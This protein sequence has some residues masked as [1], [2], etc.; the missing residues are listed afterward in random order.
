[1]PCLGHRHGGV[2]RAGEQPVLLDP[3]LEAS[4]AAP[5]AVPPPASPSAQCK[6]LRPDRLAPLTANLPSQEKVFGLSAMSASSKLMMKMATTR[7]STW[8][9]K[10]PFSNAPSR[11]PARLQT[12]LH[13]EPRSCAAARGLRGADGAHLHG[14]RD[15]ALQ[16]GITTSLRRAGI[17]QFALCKIEPC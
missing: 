7:S 1:M 13:F 2:M 15:T 10:V 6:P 3:W 16:P 11:P 5:W 17:I 4:P 12:L 8:T 14:L 9:W